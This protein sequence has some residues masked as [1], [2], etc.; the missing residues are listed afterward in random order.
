MF[1]VVLIIFLLFLFLYGLYIMNKVDRFIYENQKA[2]KDEIVLKG[3]SS[4][5]IAG[6]IPLKEIDKEIDKFKQTHPNFEVI[7]REESN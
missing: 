7:L 6:N 3:P 2:K 1:V 5:K 4:V